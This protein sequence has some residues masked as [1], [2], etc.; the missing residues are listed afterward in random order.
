MLQILKFNHNF[1]L[2]PWRW[3][4]GNSGLTGGEGA[5]YPVTLLTGK[6][7][8]TYWKKRDKEKWENWEKKEG[9]IKKGN[10]ENWKWQKEKLQNEEETFFFPFPFIFAFHFS[11]PLKFVLGLPKWE[12]SIGKKNF[13]P[14]KKSVKMTLPL[15]KIFLLLTPL[16]GNI[17]QL[18]VL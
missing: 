11:K 4:P 7:L 16:P 1:E 18:L 5:E 12:F 17:S 14:G 6:F 2:P 3:Y 15:W 9:K 10:V 13:T 8:L